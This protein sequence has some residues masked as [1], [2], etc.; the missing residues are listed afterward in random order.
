MPN[1]NLDGIK[2][3]SGEELERARK[4]VLDSI[5][6][7]DKRERKEKDISNFSLS[8]RKK[9][10]DGISSGRVRSASKKII[11][12]KNEALKKKESLGKDLG[13]EYQKKEKEAPVIL[14]SSRP[15]AFKRSLASGVA[16]IGKAAREEAEFK[17]QESKKTK[18][19][20]SPSQGG[21]EEKK[22]KK[23]KKPE[24]I[25]AKKTKK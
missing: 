15:V 25:K 7:R 12:A 14:P 2:K 8:G 5:G 1:K 10:L 9:M 6:E 16:Q 22:E 24:S 11:I 19:P 20:A 21:Q 13:V 18:K 17:K 23:E 3:L 4:I